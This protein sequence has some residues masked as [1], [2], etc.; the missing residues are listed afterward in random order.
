MNG[1][2][3]EGMR[4]GCGNGSSVMRGNLV[5]EFLL[6]CSLSEDILFQKTRRKQ[7]PKGR[8]RGRADARMVAGVVSGRLSSLSISLYSR[9]V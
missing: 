6:L 8:A 5:G 1:D 7:E 9:Q 4:A 2:K 3:K